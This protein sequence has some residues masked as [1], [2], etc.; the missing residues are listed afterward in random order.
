MAV[1]AVDTGT[2]HGASEALGYFARVALVAGFFNC[3]VSREERRTG[4]RVLKLTVMAMHH[5]GH[6]GITDLVAC[7][8]STCQI[9]CRRIVAAGT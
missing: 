6:R 3:A 8:A 5:P 9:K 7:R 2:A 4:I 1:Y